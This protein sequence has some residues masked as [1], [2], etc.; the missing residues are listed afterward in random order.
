MGETLIHQANYRERE[1]RFGGDRQPQNARQ[2]R[3]RYPIRN[4]CWCRHE[5]FRRIHRYRYHFSV[6]FFIILYNSNLITGLNVPRSRFL[7]VK[8]TSDLLLVM[9]NLYVNSTHLFCHL[10]IYLIF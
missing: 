10:T 3:Q 7:P 2:R 4:G 5:M 9:S 8:K 6:F 1:P